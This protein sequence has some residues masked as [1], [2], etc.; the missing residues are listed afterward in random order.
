MMQNISKPLITVIVPIYNVEQYIEKCVNSI[1]SQ[2]YQ[3]IEIL[4]INDGSTDNTR[5]V[6]NQYS[7]NPKCRIIDKENSGQCDC[8]YIGLEESKGEFLYFMDSDD[9]LVKDGLIKLYNS[10]SVHNSDFVCCRYKI[11]DVNGKT[12][13]VDSPFKREV[14]VGNDDI[15]HT[16]QI[17]DALWVKLFRKSFLVK[18]NIRPDRRIKLHDDCMF[19]E[20]CL[21][22][23]QK[24]SFVN[25]VL[26][27]VLERPNSVSRKIKPLMITITD[28]M[29]SIIKSEL[30]KNGQFEKYQDKYYR[31][32]AKSFVY[33][34]I[35]AAYKCHDYVMYKQLYSLIPYDSLY[36]SNEYYAKVWKYSKKYYFLSVL[37]KS[38]WLF[39]R[40]VMIISP[41][42]KH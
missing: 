31:V 21:M 14:I 37:S 24:V 40:I 15:Y 28:Q 30:V 8:R 38:P 22:K 2:S 36:Y 39:F 16:N 10:I 9:T 32:Y 12:L 6:I 13:K 29:Y 23:A 25:E 42:F 11:V 26:Y 35:L 17:K 18:N 5:K 7:M 20:L 33:S 3:N 27:C 1:L 41:F 4:L 19:T 34:L